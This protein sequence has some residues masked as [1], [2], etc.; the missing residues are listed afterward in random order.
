MDAAARTRQ[1]AATGDCSRPF[2][3]PTAAVM[4]AGYR[5]IIARAHARGIR[6]FGATIAP[7][8]GAMYWS[9]RGRIATQGHQ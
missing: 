3:K 8:E 5:Q 4:I 2:Q 7:F 1:R 9:R 6:V